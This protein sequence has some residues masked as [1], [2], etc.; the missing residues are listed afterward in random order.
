[1]DAAGTGAPSGRELATGAAGT[2]FA[3]I[4]EDVTG[5]GVGAAGTES[6]G[7]LVDVAGSPNRSSGN[8]AMAGSAFDDD[9]VALERSRC[10][11]SMAGSLPFHREFG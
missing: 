11:A 7:A 5:A 3:V 1:M 8:A 6:L 2:A 4:S 10:S 9:A